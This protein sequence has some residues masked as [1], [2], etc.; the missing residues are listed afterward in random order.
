MAITKVDTREGFAIAQAL[1]PLVD[2]NWLVWRIRILCVFQLC[3]V[4]EY[5]EGKIPRPNAETSPEDA[6]AWDF[7]DNYA[8]W[9]ILNNITDAQIIHTQGARTAKDMFDNLR[10]V[11]AARER[12]LA[13]PLLRQLMRT[14]FEDGGDIS[15]HFDRLKE[16]RWRLNMMD[17]PGFQI[18]DDFFKSI[19]AISLPASWDMFTWPYYI[20]RE[21]ADADDHRINATPQ[22]F[23]NILIEEHNRREAEASRSRPRR[24][25]LK[26]H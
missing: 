14:R 24:P 26:S 3:D 21:D 1:E 11:H 2:G 6:A 22:E 23:I 16:C 20:K 15:A 25:H 13:L 4:L 17:D 7:N 18:S 19:I 9:L 10:A 12:R 5:V 8:R